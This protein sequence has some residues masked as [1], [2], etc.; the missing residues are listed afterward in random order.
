V[1][2]P[3]ALHPGKLILMSKAFT[4]E[5]DDI[6]EPILPRHKSQL[7]AGAKNYIT[8]HG[9]RVLREELDQLK[10]RERRDTPEGKDAQN[11]GS[12]QPLRERI[13]EIE[14]SL[15]SAVIV[16][17]P[18]PPWEQVRFG[19]TVTVREKNGR[20]SRYRIVGVDETDLDRDWV[21]WCSPIARALLNARIG[22]SVRFRAPGGEQVLEIVSIA[23]D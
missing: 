6:P 5:S 19:A 2:L 10:E 20:D 17:A 13:A 15:R 22:E 8:A 4:R 21:S 16:E 23:Y 12:T 7:P 18:A 3:V 9:T 14:E 11:S 1:R